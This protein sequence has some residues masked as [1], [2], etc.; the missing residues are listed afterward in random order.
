MGIEKS[1]SFLLSQL[2]EQE[3]FL[4]V[5]LRKVILFRVVI[6]YSY[7]RKFLLKLD[8]VCVNL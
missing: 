4:L 2:G 8:Q 6:L 7:C 1:Q 3:A 5:F